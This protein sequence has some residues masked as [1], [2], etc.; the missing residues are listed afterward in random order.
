[1]AEPS[2][3]EN[4]SGQVYPASVV[5]ENRSTYFDHEERIKQLETRLA[6]LA[7]RYNKNLSR[8]FGLFTRCPPLQ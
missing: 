2:T 8:L 6:E 7:S 4:V 1:M 5:V 3:L